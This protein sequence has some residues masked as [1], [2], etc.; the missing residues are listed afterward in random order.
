[1][2]YNLLLITAI[3]SYTTGLETETIACVV[4]SAPEVTEHYG[5]D[6]IGTR[7]RAPS[8]TL[9]LLVA[10][11]AALEKWSFK[12]ESELDAH[13][14]EAA[15]GDSESPVCEPNEQVPYTEFSYM[16]LFPKEMEG[17]F[18]TNVTFFFY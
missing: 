16:Y 9:F 8:G 1:M 10:I 3:N 6:A 15:S 11:K 4:I 12:T 14:Y 7:M 2:L 13:V 17:A 18:S 5:N